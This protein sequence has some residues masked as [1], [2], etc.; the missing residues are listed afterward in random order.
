M[1]VF[2]RLLD[3]VDTDDL[4]RDWLRSLIAHSDIVPPD[5]WRYIAL[6]EGTPVP[7]PY[8]YRW[9]APRVLGADSAK[10]ST[11]N[12]VSVAAMVPAMRWLT[13]KWGPGLFAFT[14][15]GV[16]T[17][18]R[19][20]PVVTDPMAQLAAIIAAAATKQRRWGIAT[21]ASLIAGAIR[22]TAPV[23][24][25]A[26]ADHPLPLIGLIAPAIRH[27]HPEG[28]DVADDFSA[29]A[30][31]QP[32]WAAWWVRRDS[33]RDPKLWLTPWGGLLAGVRGDRRT[34]LTLAVAYAQTVA[35]VDT[36]RLV[37]WAWPVLADN[38]TDDN[39]WP[40]ALAASWFNPWRSAP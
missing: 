16:W 33:S 34:I 15:D 2:D 12:A 37:Q 32:L 3:R 9:L 7:R 19:R 26:Y 30:V 25:A 18:A 35:A 27:R 38:A 17:L 10:W 36:T 39:R 28:P 13:G 1:T 5:G 11:A 22:E 6:A 24:A 20:Y 4:H 23:F 40:L 29:D 8:H 31:R 14:L 21:A